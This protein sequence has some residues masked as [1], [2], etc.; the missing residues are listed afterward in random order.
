MAIVLE[1]GI[2]RLLEVRIRNF[3]TAQPTTE[4][5]ITNYINEESI[6][7]SLT[8]DETGKGL[9]LYYATRNN[10]IY[11]LGIIP[12][13]SEFYTT[14]G[15]DATDYVIEKILEDLGYTAGLNDV[16][17]FEYKVWYKPYT[18]SRMFN[19]KTN[20]S[21]FKNSS[22]K[23]F[24]QDDNTISDV[25]FGNSVSTQIERV[26][27]NSIQKNYRLSSYSFIPKL[28]QLKVFE[29]EKYYAD[30]I[31]YT[32]N[33]NYID[34]EVNYSK[35]I[36]KINERVGIDAAYRPYRIDG[37]SNVTRD[38]NINHYCY[39]SEESLPYVVTSNYGV[40]NIVSSLK[41]SLYDNVNN[42]Y[43]I[44]KDRPVSLYIKNLNEDR[45]RLQYIDYYG[46]T[47]DVPASLLS[48]SYNS[49]KNNILMTT[50][51]R[52]NYSSGTSSSESFL[53]ETTTPHV[54]RYKQKDV[55]YTD[56][57]GE[58]TY[59]QF[60]ICSPT[61]SQI[62]I[63]AGTIGKQLPEAKYLSTVSGYLSNIFFDNEYFIDKDNREK[64]RFNYQLHFKTF[65]KR[66][67]N[68]VGLFKYLF[69]NNVFGA[70]TPA[71]RNSPVLAFYNGNFSD[72][73]YLLGDVQELTAPFVSSV[74]S[75][76]GSN[77][78]YIDA[79][80]ATASKS[81]MGYAYI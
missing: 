49:F 78:V 26:G 3:L 40:S 55:R 13:A 25:S 60:T 19:E 57:N 21:G 20:L 34:V 72:K 66:I 65:D 10:K 42:K 36:N 5:S 29:S 31:S 70:T 73:N 48:L 62:L 23:A 54:T 44:P 68:G 12:Q 28:G 74:S 45:N 11:G 27:N 15:W 59:M 63:D 77:Y 37:N 9:S 22:Y 46:D 43:A 16:N 30:Q 75:G 81:Y 52:T 18:D 80:T 14:M 51:F 50:E 2:S 17:E 33:N 35:N 69:K 8:S 58:N 76:T 38:I 41:S 61:G 64:I 6:Y 53:D 1:K 56:N 24:N 67:H 71:A 32:F 4:A 7:N 79:L 39:A 47:K